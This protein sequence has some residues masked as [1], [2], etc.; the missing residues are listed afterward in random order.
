METD[1]YLLQCLTNAGTVE[2]I[3]DIIYSQVFPVVVFFHWQLSIY[4]NSL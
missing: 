4:G 2:N 3:W 1:P